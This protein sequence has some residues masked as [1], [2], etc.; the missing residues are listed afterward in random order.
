MP[1]VVMAAIRV[2][3]VVPAVR[4]VITVMVLVDT[5]SAAVVQVPPHLH[6][7]AVDVLAAQHLVADG[8]GRTDGRDRVELR[9]PGDEPPETSST[10]ALRCLLDAGV[11]VLGLSLEGGRLSDAFLAVTQGEGDG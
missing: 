10:A 2:S 6:S 11:P 5:P 1:A 4:P 8:A 9:L 3:Y 7:R